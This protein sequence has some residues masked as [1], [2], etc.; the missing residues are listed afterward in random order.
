MPSKKRPAPAGGDNSEP[1]VSPPD[2]GA[3]GPSHL[4]SLWDALCL[5]ETPEE[6]RGALA[7]L[8]LHAR[9]LRPE[10]HAELAALIRS[11]F[12]RRRGP[13]EKRR[14][15]F[16]IYW[17]YIAFGGRRLLSRADAIESIAEHYNISQEAAAKAYDMAKKLR[18]GLQCEGK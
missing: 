10:E 11:G 3:G 17:T 6:A 5:T 2:L 15:Q 9:H 4:D 18:G 7:D 1:D 12:K 13:P 16:D 8:V 14:R